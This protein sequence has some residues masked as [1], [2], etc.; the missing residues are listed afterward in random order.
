MEITTRDYKRINVIRVTGRVDA[1]TTP[2]FETKLKEYIACGH[3]HL[4]L[5]MDG[6]DYISSA[7]LRVLISAQ[8]ALKVKGGRL[9]IA[10][11]SERVK[12]VAAGTERGEKGEGAADVG[13]D[14]PSEA[15]NAATTV[16]P[17]HTSPCTKRNI[18]WAWARSCS[19]SPTTRCCALVN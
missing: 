14:R 8:K 4:V 13:V 10:Q 11:P 16:L 2:E 3:T 17:E 9:V 12:E 15:A 6:A 18:A 19:I 1:V 7:G 5:E